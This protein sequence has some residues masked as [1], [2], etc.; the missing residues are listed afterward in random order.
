MA[1][2]NKPMEPVRKYAPVFNAIVAS[3]APMESHANFVSDAR[4]FIKS[5]CPEVL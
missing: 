3:A 5:L 1:S 2:D 4:S